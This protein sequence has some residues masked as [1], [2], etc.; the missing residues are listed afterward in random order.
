MVTT[1]LILISVTFVAMMSP[2]PDMMLLVKYSAAKKHST[3]ALCIA[4]ICS[5]VTVH[6]ALSI[7]GIAA[8]IAASTTL[9]F[10]LKL[11]GAAYLIYIGI[12]SLLSK[13]GLQ[14]DKTIKSRSGKRI[15]PFRDGFLCNVLNPKVTIFILAVF[16]QIVDP[17]TPVSEKVLYGLCIVLESFIVWNVFVMLIRTRLVLSFIQRNQVTIERIVGVALIGFGG[18]LAIDETM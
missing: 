17:F 18:L 9:Y 4:G 15:N 13:G 5:G 12:L 10:S 1:L 14:L 11:A 8:V 7:L 16:T 3:A 6:V 2:G